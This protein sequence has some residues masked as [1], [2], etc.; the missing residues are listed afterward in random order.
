LRIENLQS[1]VADDFN[2]LRAA[3]Y[4]D[5]AVVHRA[6]IIENIRVAKD[7]YR[8]RVK[9]PDI[10]ATIRPGQ[11][12]MLRLA[13]CDDPLVG[14][15]LA[16]YDTYLSDRGVPESLDLVYLVVGKLT[17]HLAAAQAGTM[18][19]LWGPLGN[20]FPPAEADH[21][22]LVA[23]GIGHTPFL[24]VANEW[25]GKKRYGDGGSTRGRAHRI[26][27]C[28]GTRSRE[29]L[30]CVG[31]YMSA[32]VN[33]RIATDDGTEG[34]PGLVTEDLRDLLEA[35]AADRDRKHIFCCGPEPMME[36]T[37]KLA[38]EFAIPCHVSLETPMACG[39]GICF[40]CVTR[41]WQ[42]DGE[43]DYKRTCVEGPIFD[44]ARIAW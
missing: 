10:V 1:P 12:V 15:A 30:S 39:I 41:V 13:G 8:V 28:Y 18:V 19:D 2:P 29:F 24:A 43:W 3:C 31:D 36:A 5:R 44:A 16:L 22:I 6:P 34:R 25:L 23:G 17:R 33:V 21:L 20:G 37:A 38:N 14:R 4:A 7:T 9:A 35:T 27:L 26:T 40:S 11:F 42:A 32:G